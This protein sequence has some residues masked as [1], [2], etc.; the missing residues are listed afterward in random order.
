[1]QVLYCCITI[2]EGDHWPLHTPSCSVLVFDYELLLACQLGLTGGNRILICSVAVS[3]QRVQSLSSQYQNSKIKSW[4]FCCCVILS[5]VS[6]A[7]SSWWKENSFF[8]IFFLPRVRARATELKFALGFIGLHVLHGCRRLHVC[9]RR[10]AGQDLEL[11]QDCWPKSG[12]ATVYRRAVT[13]LEPGLSSAACFMFP[14]IVWRLCWKV[15]CVLAF[16]RPRSPRAE[17]T[18]QSCKIV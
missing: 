12:T 10:R 11:V 13:P 16:S 8:D 6:E 9:W 2:S 14:L 5:S 18:E 7:D 1:M 15:C 4:G 3:A 17:V